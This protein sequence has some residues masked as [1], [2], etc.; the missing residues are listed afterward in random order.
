ML[1]QMFKRFFAARAFHLYKQHLEQ[2]GS[3]AVFVTH[4]HDGAD[5]RM[6]P[7]KRTSHEDQFVQMLPALQIPNRSRYSKVQDHSVRINFKHESMKLLTELIALDDKSAASVASST[8]AVMDQALSSILSPE[9]TPSPSSQQKVTIVHCLTGD[10]IPMNIAAA[11]IVLHSYL[12]NSQ[13]K[14][15]VRYRLVLV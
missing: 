10:A 6:R 14:P 13:Y 12:S 5:M 2:A 15:I 11:R 3:A 9:E 8:I 4:C 7:D 1:Q